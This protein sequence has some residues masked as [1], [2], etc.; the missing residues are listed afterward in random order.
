[1]KPLGL[2]ATHTNPPLPPSQKQ[3]LDFDHLSVATLQAPLKP[4]TEKDLADL[5]ASQSIPPLGGHLPIAV[6]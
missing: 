3:L 2:H 6:F 4:Q 5:S 1:M